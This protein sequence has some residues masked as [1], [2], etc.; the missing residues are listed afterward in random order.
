MFKLN[1]VL[2][3][4]KLENLQDDESEA[5]KY[6]DTIK[7]ILK[8]L[9]N[10]SDTSRQSISILGTN[11]QLRSFV[12]MLKAEKEFMES[13]RDYG[14]DHLQTVAAKEKVEK[15]AQQFERTMGIEWPLK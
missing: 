15:E 6:A 5:Q 9:L 12:K 1:V 14:S 2:E 8:S 11:S 4:N 3:I 7:D 10:Y 13:Y